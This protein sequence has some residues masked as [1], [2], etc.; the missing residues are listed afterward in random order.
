M[1]WG[2]KHIYDILLFYCCCIKVDGV[3]M[4][5]FTH[6]NKGGNGIKSTHTICTQH[7]HTSWDT[8]ERKVIELWDK[9][10]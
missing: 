7:I 10:W 4:C 3:F 8:R 1:R 9:W 2:N 5:L 6:K